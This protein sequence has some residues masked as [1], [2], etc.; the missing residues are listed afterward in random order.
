[1]D[2]MKIL[3]IGS[4]FDDL[5]LSC[6][7]TIAKFASQGHII[8]SIMTA[9]SDYT[10]YNGIILRTEQQA[11]EEGT[12]GLLSLGVEKVICLNYPTKDVPFDS[13]I[14]ES[15]NRWI[16]IFNP[17]IIITHALNESHPDHYNTAKSVMAAARY[18]KTIWMFE[19]LYPSKTSTQLFRPLIYVD[20]SNF[21]NLKLKSLQEHKS[22]IEKY[23]YWKDLII[24]LARVRGIEIGTQYAEVFDVIK[25]EYK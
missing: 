15:L 22:Q 18:Q 17:D 25:M 3:T 1:M 11:K 19:T 21:L 9:K 13:K 16:D 10:S 7:G 5:E 2:K 24:S 4:H 20:I 23:S 8:W 12:K 14:I 6:G